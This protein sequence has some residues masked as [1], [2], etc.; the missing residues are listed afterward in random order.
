MRS[1]IIT[2]HTVILLIFAGIFI[3]I[4][5][6]SSST[7]YESQIEVKE[8]GWNSNDFLRYEFSIQDTAVPYHFYVNIRNSVDYSYSNLFLFIRTQLP[9]HTWANDTIDLMLADPTGKWLGR[10]NGKYRDCQVLVMPGFRFPSKG[11]YVFEIEHAMRDTELKG[12]AAV[13]VLVEASSK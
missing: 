2:R 9:D 6:C 4:Q 13:G 8:D 3:T 7:V 12:I 1:S 10:G 11:E 5:G